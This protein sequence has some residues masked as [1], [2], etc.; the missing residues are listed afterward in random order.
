M[1]KWL[2][3]AVVIIQALIAALQSGKLQATPDH[4]AVVSQLKA[5][6]A[7]LTAAGPVDWLTVMALLRKIGP[8]LP[9]LIADAKPVIADLQ[10]ILAA[11]QS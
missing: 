9:Q 8:L 3:L 7:D 5:L 6:E 4:L 11:L 2:Q 10:Q 1:D